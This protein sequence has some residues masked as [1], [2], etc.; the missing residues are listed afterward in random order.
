VERLKKLAYAVEEWEI[1]KAEGKEPPKRKRLDP[2]WGT[3][4]SFRKQVMEQYKNML[5]CHRPSRRRIAGELHKDE[6]F[7]PIPG[8]DKHFTKRIFAGELKPNYLRVPKGWK[9]LWQKLENAKSKSEERRIRSQMLALEDVKP[10]KS[11]VVRDRWFREELRG[12]LRQNDFDPDSFGKDKESAKRFKEFVKS[13]G[14]ILKSGV[15][16]RRI[17]LLR[18]LKDPIK[19]IQRK[20][21]DIGTGKMIYDT[22]PKSLRIYDSQN[23]HHIEIREDEKGKWFGEVVRNYDA[24]KRNIERLKAL[25][26]AGVPSAREMQKLK[27]NNPARYREIQGKYSPVISRINQDYSI[28][29]RKDTDDGR[30]VMSLSIGEMV[31]MKH[32]ETGKADYFVVFKIDKPQT[33]H[34]TPHYD[35]G[36]DKET[37]KCPKRKDI[38]LSPP[39]LQRL[40]TEPGL[41]PQK[42]WVG[43]V[44]DV[45]VLVRD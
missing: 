38:D 14:L 18:T 10:E 21:F 19:D 28:V 33:I 39:Q 2:P 24:A 26:D 37:E 36:R 41:P 31:R 20:K 1:A 8:D 4:E 34:F 35:A 44:G 43:P 16:V 3:V 45:K 25:K 29:S 30:F 11:G 17:T 23:N 27:K 6:H 15:P 9:E 42:V 22:N 13:T 7:G 40:G 32:P 12:C 5:V